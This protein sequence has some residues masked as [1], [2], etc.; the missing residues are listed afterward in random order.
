MIL[1]VAFLNSMCHNKMQPG[2][3][4]GHTHTHTH[5]TAFITVSLD[6]EI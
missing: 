5:Q 4:D 6:T 3:Y 1:V 2:I